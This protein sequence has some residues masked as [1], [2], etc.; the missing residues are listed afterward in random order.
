MKLNWMRHQAFPLQAGGGRGWLSF[1]VIAF[2]LFLYHRAKDCK[3][4]ASSCSI[5]PYP[6]QLGGEKLGAYLLVLFTLFFTH[7]YAQDIHP[8]DI[9]QEIEITEPTP[10]STFDLPKNPTKAAF[11]SAFIPGAGQIYNEKYLKAGAI[12][13]VQGWL[14]G[15][16]F[17]NH[18]K[19]NEYKRK[20]NEAEFDSNDYYHY[21]MM[22][23]DYYERRQSFIYWVGA[24]VLLSAME[25]YVDAHLINF[26]DKK[27]EIK[28]KFEDEK[29]MVEFKF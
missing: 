9:Y 16:A 22:Y 1:N 11:L 2:T 21:Q 24:S 19:M 15:T 3:I 27:N 28:L 8:P 10:K 26:K 23:K 7:V 25:A 18:S 6:L 17:Y 20:R 13:G 12:I 5:T 29:V 4:T 14:V